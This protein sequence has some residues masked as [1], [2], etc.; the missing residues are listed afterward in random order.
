[1]A[2]GL[3]EV[4]NSD[5]LTRLLHYSINYDRKKWLLVVRSNLIKT[6]VIYL[7]DFNVD[8]ILALTKRYFIKRLILEGRKRVT[9]PNYE[10]DY[11]FGGKCY[12]NQS[13]LGTNNLAFFPERL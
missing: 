10:V 11:N 3:L 1:M 2:S 6:Y 9:T 12:T 7:K 13:L 8:F 4:T 5:K